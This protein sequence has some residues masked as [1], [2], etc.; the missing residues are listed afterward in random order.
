MS[1]EAQVQQLQKDYS[2]LVHAMQSGVALD[3]SL[4][5][6]VDGTPKHL[7][8]GINV[9]MSDHAALVRIL[10]SRGLITEVEYWQAM[11]DSMRTEK[12]TYD[13]QYGVKIA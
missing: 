13:T 5:G 11:C 1:D 2:E 9:C 3:H 8:V 10:I 4:R 7:R 6:P 12:E